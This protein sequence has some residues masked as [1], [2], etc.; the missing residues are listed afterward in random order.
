MLLKHFIST[1]L[2]ISGKSSLWEHHGLQVLKLVI[3]IATEHVLRESAQQRYLLHRR[4][5]VHGQRG[6]P[7]RLLRWGRLRQQR[8]LALAAT[9]ATAS[10]EHD[11]EHDASADHLFCVPIGMGFNAVLG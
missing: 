8:W 10:G 5:I 2:H 7:G 4:R 6:R 3:L 11:D 9:A 1:Q